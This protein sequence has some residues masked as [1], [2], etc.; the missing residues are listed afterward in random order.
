M[1]E[2]LPIQRGF[3]GHKKTL[4]AD[5]RKLL[6]TRIK[7]A[8]WKKP[9]RESRDK[10]STSGTIPSCERY[11]KIGANRNMLVLTSLNRGK[12][13]LQNTCATKAPISSWLIIHRLGSDGYI[14]TNNSERNFGISSRHAVSEKSALACETFWQSFDWYTMQWSRFH[15]YFPKKHVWRKTKETLRY[16]SQ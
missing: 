13:E 5:L 2:T 10:N 11:K 6:A 14:N 12:A 3:F 4:K 8:R 7:Q 15:H 16:F 9:T 1:F